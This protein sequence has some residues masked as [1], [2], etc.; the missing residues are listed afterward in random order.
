[1]ESTIPKSVS[2]SLL[3][4]R[5]TISVFWFLVTKDFEKGNQKPSVK[6]K[7]VL[8]TL[9]CHWMLQQCRAQ[10]DCWAPSAG[11]LAGIMSRLI[12][13]KYKCGNASLFA[14]RNSN[15]FFSK[16]STNLPW[17]QNC[18]MYDSQSCPSRSTNSLLAF[19]ALLHP[20]N[21]FMMRFS[22]PTQLELLYK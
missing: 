5:R 4:F 1:M 12:V 6:T 19:K 3:V 17:Q 15:P 14:A 20:N 16:T 21:F 10:C 9:Y 8:W 13:S 2:F 18:F 22:E 7:R 11:W